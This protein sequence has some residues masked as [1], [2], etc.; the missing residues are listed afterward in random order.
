MK[1][2][3]GCA[4]M[5]TPGQEC[6]EKG[7]RLAVFDLHKF[8]V[9]E[10]DHL[11]PDPQEAAKARALSS[12]FPENHNSLSSEEVPVVETHFHSDSQWNLCG[13]CT[14]SIIE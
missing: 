9:P 5:K 8:S 2:C 3:G 11:T 4:V 13:F 7:R 10:L 1:V 12:V 14:V 6:H